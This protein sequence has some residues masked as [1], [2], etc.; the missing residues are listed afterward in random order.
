MLQLEL[1]PLSWKHCTTD[2]CNALRGFGT[3]VDDADDGWN[4]EGSS[5]YSE[6]NC[7]CPN[8]KSLSDHATFTCCLFS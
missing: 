7:E 6:V 5:N 1:E 3:G 8:V 4:P 2:A